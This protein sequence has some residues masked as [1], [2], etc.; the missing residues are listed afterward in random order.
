MCSTHIFIFLK[1]MH[2]WQS[3]VRYDV[4]YK[5]MH[6]S[7]FWLSNSSA[8]MTSTS[9]LSSL[10]PSDAYMRRWT[11]HIWRQAIIW[12]NALNSVNWS[13]RNKLQW[14]FNRN[15]KLFIQDNALEDVV[16]EMASICLDLN[17]LSL[18]TIR[19]HARK[20]W[21]WRYVKRSLRA[22]ISTC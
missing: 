11:H 5:R 6:H 1:G 15:S 7:V 14:H 10:R 21:W 12:T 8:R 16:C 18:S 9:L 19:S 17:V 3:N 2:E 13:L 4:Q 22:D 20:S